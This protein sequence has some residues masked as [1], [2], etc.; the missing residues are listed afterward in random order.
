MFLGVAGVCGLCMCVGDCVF[1]VSF[2]IC[3]VYQFCVCV[4]GCGVC[5]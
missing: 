5:R 4:E 2:L 3:C 1:G